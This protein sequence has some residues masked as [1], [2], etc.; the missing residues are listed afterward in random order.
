M[1]G[2]LIIAV[3][4]SAIGGLMAALDV[5]LELR[6]HLDRQSARREAIGAGVTTFAVLVALSVAASYL[7]HMIRW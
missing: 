5:Y 4:F 3:P 2:V 1:G 6:H 7:M